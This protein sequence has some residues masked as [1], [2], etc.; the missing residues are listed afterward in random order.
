LAFGDAV[1]AETVLR[2]VVEV[3]LVID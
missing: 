2:R 3:M 1:A